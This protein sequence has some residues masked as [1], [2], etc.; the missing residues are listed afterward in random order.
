MNKKYIFVFMCVAVVMV[1]LFSKKN[2]ESVGVDKEQTVSYEHSPQFDYTNEK[3]ENVNSLHE[4]EPSELSQQTAAVADSLRSV[5]ST[6]LSELA[7]ETQ[8]LKQI[9]EMEEDIS[10]MNDVNDPTDVSAIYENF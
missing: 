10:D 5:S 6:E 9:D 4:Q 8:Y 3:K 7:D 2:E 1:L